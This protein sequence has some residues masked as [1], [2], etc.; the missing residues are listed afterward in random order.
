MN[1]YFEANR[2]V[3]PIEE[4]FK[5][6]IEQYQ[7]SHPVRL[8]AA[9]IEFVSRGGDGALWNWLGGANIICFFAYIDK[10][11]Q[12]SHESLQ[13]VGAD[14]GEFFPFLL[15]HAD[16]FWFFR[17]DE[18]DDPP[19]YMFNPQVYQ[20]I[21]PPITPWPRGVEKVTN[22]FTEFVFEESKNQMDA[23]DMK[24]K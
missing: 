13:E 8:P 10:I 18:G 23:P 20:A 24:N 7:A 1:L 9:Y 19:V 15:I 12:Y 2:K 14:I 4:Q 16:Y 11:I 3:G 6:G 22:S 5:K 17:L 21:A